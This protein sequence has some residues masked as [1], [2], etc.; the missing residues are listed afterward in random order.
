MSNKS[1]VL[2]AI[3]LFICGIYSLAQPQAGMQVGV[4][5]EN[6]CA[7]SDLR[8][9]HRDIRSYFNDILISDG[10]E[11]LPDSVA[12][13]LAHAYRESNAKRNGTV[14]VEQK[15][16]DFF[17][18][19]FTREEKGIIVLSAIVIEPDRR[20]EQQNKLTELHKS[21]FSEDY[22]KSAKLLTY[23]LA[24]KL[25][26][27]SEGKLSNELEKL[28]LWKVAIIDGRSEDNHKYTLLSF[29]PP[30]NQ[31]KAGTTKGTANG[32]A[33]CAGYAVSVGTFIGST[34]SYNNNLRLYNGVSDDQPQADK[35]RNQYSRQMN[36]CRAMQIGSGLLFIGTYA[37][38][39]TN[40]LI[41][42]DS[43][44]RDRKLTI[45]PV[46]YENGAGLAMV[47]KF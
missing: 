40:A 36:T 14:Q 30:V 4:H 37:Y 10:I 43:Y 25:G 3:C 42:R 35:A 38:G 24:D 44:Q 45:T 19:I 15:R 16:T 27:I 22:S 28:R 17:Y 34:V 26:L 41:N 7:S 13:D 20:H 21:F 1:C 12:S 8:N 33:I 47:Y 5:I 9:L 2:A 11:I 6:S 39:V 31:F 32:I 29:L 46:A 23:E 18:Q